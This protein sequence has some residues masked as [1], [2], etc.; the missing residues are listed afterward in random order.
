MSKNEDEITSMWRSASKGHFKTK[1]NNVIGIDLGTTNS[2]VGI[3]SRTE[4]L[5]KII[6]IDEQPTIP[7][8]LLYQGT[9]STPL[10]GHEA[11]KLLC[12]TPKSSLFNAKRFLGRTYKEIAS[13]ALL[14]PFD[15]VPIESSVDPSSYTK[16]DISK[17]L[18]HFQHKG[19]TCELLPEEVSAMVLRYI[20]VKSEEWLNDKENEWNSNDTSITACVITVP[21][22]FGYL[23]RMAT[24][25]AAIRAGFEEVRLV[26]ESTAAAMAYG[27][28]VA[29]QKRIVV[30]D[31]GGGT[32]DVSILDVNDGNFQVVAMGGN[33]FLGGND[34]DDLLLRHVLIKICHALN[35][36]KDIPKQRK[37]RNH[38]STCKDDIRQICN[39]LQINMQSN[40]FISF[41]ENVQ[42]AK[43]KAS[44][45][46]DTDVEI[47]VELEITLR[48][49][50]KTMYKNTMKLNIIND[51]E[52]VIEPIVQE[53]IQTVQDVISNGSKKDGTTTISTTSIDEV[54]LV[55]GPTRMPCIRRAIQ[56]EFPSVILCKDINPDEVVAEGEY[57]IFLLRL[58]SLLIN[59]LNFL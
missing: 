43:I 29:G 27:V 56:K 1:A 45:T 24:K 6:Q 15:V 33:E 12:K 34:I 20:R 4:D 44:T 30:Y 35:I 55:G 40:T 58:L 37:K 48:S 8:V 53:T 31:L 9:T 21:A 17:V 19:T 39:V 22:R 26:A 36:Y 23:Q 2:C 32:F 50:E 57:D 46:D 51:I 18:F 41:Q 3:W 47:E 38:R 42:N 10:V 5:V 28:G 14:C 16:E 52:H 54:I 25:R 11:K 59:R 13:E 7:S 49:N